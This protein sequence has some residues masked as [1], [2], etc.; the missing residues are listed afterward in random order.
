MGKL[1]IIALGG[2]PCTGKTTIMWGIRSHLGKP[3]LKKYGML[4]YEEYPDRKIII[5][6]KYQEGDTFAGTD[7][8][9]MSVQPTVCDFIKEN[10][11]Q[12]YTILFEGDRLFNKKLFA[13]I[14]TLDLGLTIYIL[15][16][17]MVQY[18]ANI[19]KRGSVHSDT[20]VKGRRTK[21]LN[22]QYDK[23]FPVKIISKPSE[24]VI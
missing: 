24:L 22:I 1:R 12:S 6:G 20:F 16:P 15:E 23:T 17:T 8:L 7:R 9:P 14:K 4:T 10:R 11:N 21:L 19:R 18:L 3:V 5:L 13:F 2:L